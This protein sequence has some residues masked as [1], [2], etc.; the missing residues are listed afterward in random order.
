MTSGCGNT[1]ASKTTMS[2]G[3]IGRPKG[4]IRSTTVLTEW[5]QGP[6]AARCGPDTVPSWQCSGAFLYDGTITI[7][8]GT[9]GGSFSEAYAINNAGAAV[10]YA[11]NAM[12]QERAF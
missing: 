6:L 12:G 5:L 4:T 10:G 2:L 7:D 1:V 3:K 9:F 8:L 11:T